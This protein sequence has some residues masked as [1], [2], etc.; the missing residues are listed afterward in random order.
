MS[1]IKKTTDNKCCW[2]GGEKRALVQ[3]CGS[4]NCWGHN[5]KQQEIA[6]KIKNSTTIWSSNSTS[7][8]VSKGN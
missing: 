5:G 2:G 4:V 7:G 3:D 8:Y 6:Q 1:V